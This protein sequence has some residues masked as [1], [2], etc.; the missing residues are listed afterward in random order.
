MSKKFLPYDPDQSFLLPANPRGWLDPDHPVFFVIRTVKEL[1]LAAFYMAYKEGP[2]APPHDPRLMVSIL[3]Y[4][5]MRACRSSRHIE[6]SLHED[7]GFRV[8]AGQNGVDHDS[9]CS[10]RLRHRE[11]LEGLFVQVL[12]VC[13][14]AGLLELDH[15]AGDGTK[16]HANASKRKANTLGRLREKEAALREREEKL[17]KDVSSWLDELDEND[18]KDDEKYGKRN[19]YSVPPELVDADKQ[20]EFIRRTIKE[21]E[22]RER[23]EAKERGRRSDE[24][25]E[26]AQV[27]F[28][29]PDSR[30]MPDSADKGR[31]VQA[32]NAQLAVNTKQIIVGTF[33]TNHPID[34]PHLPEIVHVI[35]KNAGHYP[36]EMSF[37]AGFAKRENLVLLDELGIDG[38]VSMSKHKRDRIEGKNPVGRPPK[39]DDPLVV[40][41]HKLQTPRGKRRY[42]LRKQLVEP[43]IGQ[44]KQAMGFRRFLLRGIEKVNME[45]SMA[46]TAHNLRKVWSAQARAS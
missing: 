46:C 38:Y 45:W 24:P 10:F 12:K 4:G 8:L 35:H 28:T 9:I 29:D 27:N 16:V 32:Y 44:L 18:R 37:D 22:E 3:L 1:D 39:S 31:F 6:R 34:N 23:E 43:V 17:R 40:M 42:A 11:N 5:N 21:L 26:A 33:V 36:E 2:G 19:G 20:R 25:R 41:T 13:E 30:V 14:R 15:V 7:I